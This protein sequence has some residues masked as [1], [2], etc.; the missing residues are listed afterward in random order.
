MAT[1]LR[2]YRTAL[3]EVGVKLDSSQDS[4]SR[5]LIDDVTYNAVLAYCLEQGEWNFASRKNNI[6]STGT[7]SFGYSYLFTKPDDWVRTT[8]LSADSSFAVPL[9]DYVDEAAQ[10]QANVPIL[11]VTYVS[12]HTSYG[13][14][15]SH[16]PESYTRFVELELAHRI[17]PRSE[18]K[19]WQIEALEARLKKAKQSA[20]GKDAQNEAAPRMIQPGRFVQSRFGPSGLF[21]RTRP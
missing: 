12:I 19:A 3:H 18:L 10:W 6:F 4:V 15:L 11:Y 14:N 1:A 7:P 16:W 20:L 13:M 21:D 5:S 2:L 8:M 9:E 17:A